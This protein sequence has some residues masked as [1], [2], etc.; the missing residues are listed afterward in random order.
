MHRRSGR[1]E[2]NRQT[3]GSRTGKQRSKASHGNANTHGGF[4]DESIFESGAE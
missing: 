1:L 3:A 2:R 4:P